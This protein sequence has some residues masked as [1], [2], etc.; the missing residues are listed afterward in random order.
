[1]SDND[2]DNEAINENEGNAVAHEQRKDN[3]EESG[4]EDE[5]DESSGDEGI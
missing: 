1:M 2:E 5:M 3:E 4:F